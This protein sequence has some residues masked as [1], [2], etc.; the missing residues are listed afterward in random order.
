MR[1][2]LAKG[3]TTQAVDDLWGGVAGERMSVDPFGDIERLVP[4]SSPLGGPVPEA[5]S[6]ERDCPY[7]KKERDLMD[8]EKR[9]DQRHNYRRCHSRPIES[10]RDDRGRDPLALP[11]CRRPRR[12]SGTRCRYR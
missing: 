3:G 7:D 10:V 8:Q 11:E 2:E 5:A 9:Y 12:Y 6:A 1:T 4:C